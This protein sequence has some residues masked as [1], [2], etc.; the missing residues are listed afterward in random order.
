VGMCLIAAAFDLS[1][2]G[3]W[4]AVVAAVAGGLGAVIFVHELGHFLVAKAC[5]VKCE[6]F[7]IGFDVG[8][9]KIS[10][11]WGETEYGIGI[12]PLGGYVKMLG[13]DDNP[14]NI[15]EQVR[16]SQVAG[17]AIEAKEITGPD[18]KKYLIDK[19]SYLA[20]SVPQRMAIISAG[21][22]MNIIFAFI[23]A[24]IAF[25]LG[26]PFNPAIVSRTGPGTPAWQKDVRPGDEIIRIGDVK[27]PSFDDLRGSVSLGDI[28]AGIP[29][30]I[31]RDGET[32]TK[33][34]F[35]RQ[36]RGLP[37]VGIAPPASLVIYDVDGVGQDPKTSLQKDDEIVSVDGQPVATYAEF[38]SILARRPG[39]ALKVTARRGG[40]PAKDDPFGPRSGGKMV[41]VTL[42]PRPLKT[43][44]L[45]MKIGKVVAVQEGSPADGKLKPGDFI[46]SIADAAE[47]P[48]GDGSGSAL[49][50][51]PI[52]L[53]EDLR[54]MAEDNREVRITFRRNTP[55]DDGRREP[56]TVVIPLRPVEWLEGPLGGEN[57][58]VVATSLGIAYSVLNVVDRVEPGSPADLAGMKSGDVVTH[59]ELVFPDDA[60]EKPDF[61]PFEFS[62]QDEDRQANWP[63]LM[64]VI[65]IRDP[66][67]KV[68]LSYKRG[69][70]VVPVTLTPLLSEKYFTA[71][72]GLG[73]D[74]VE[75][76]RTAKTWGE[77]VERG[78]G[79]TVSALGLVYRFLGKLGTQVSVTSL[80]GPI[81]IAKA[82]SFSAEQGAGKLLVFLTMLSAN[83]AVI[84]FLPIPLLDGGH[85]VFLL[86]EGIRGKPASER[87]VV[88]MHTAG[89]VF[90][91]TLMLFVLS[92]DMGLIDRNL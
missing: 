90:I 37:Q 15:A 57:E 79:E 83:L 5:G 50:F 40:K 11:K 14:A 27:D 58:P 38:A 20:K 17:N 9:Y 23:F 7:F 19:R 78:W 82:A 34:L 62:S 30:E 12:L 66:A 91:I 84:N 69:D 73:Y 68:A 86:W 77:A 13:Q 21:V 16:E 47:S 46:D 80:G 75:K 67:P 71:E 10:R 1:L 61:G 55:G 64:A 24:T 43:L 87:F 54:R 45:V 42:P 33:T 18:G 3:Y 41:E 35:P 89:F 76:I 65:Q 48:G 51:D 60:K 92:L 8:G 39:D 25:K 22:I 70:E 85:M 4:A 81:T 74:L 88:A 29:F 2:I 53:P 49:V 63:Q 59:A 52:T 72:R 44:G 6:K 32:V 28:E 31:R 56:E 36:G 26:V